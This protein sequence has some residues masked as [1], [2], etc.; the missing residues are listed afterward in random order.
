LNKQQLKELITEAKKIKSDII[1]IRPDGNIYGTDI[2]FFHLKSSTTSILGFELC[3]LSKDMD[4]F[5]KNIDDIAVEKI[6][7]NG[8]NMIA[9]NG[10]VVQVLN[11][12]SINEINNKIIRL[13][14]M[15]NNPIIYTNESLQEDD[16]FQSIISLKTSD[17]STIYKIDYIYMM[18]VFK[19]LLPINKGDKVLLNIIDIGQERFLSNF[20]VVKKKNVII[21]IYYI[22]RYLNTSNR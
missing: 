5:I 13:S 9:E 16:V 7:I 22:M 2:N 21:N 4:A 3:Y 12:F 15:I 10:A 8:I 17:G 11:P 1:Y 20:T 18:S 14:Y 6:I 19:T